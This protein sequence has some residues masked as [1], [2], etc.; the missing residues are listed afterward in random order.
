MVTIQELSKKCG[1]SISTVSK[2]LNGYSDISDKTREK[3]I[4]T[5]N[6]VGYYS[7]AN[8]K[9]YKLKKTYNIGV[10]FHTLT[11]LGLKN[12]YFAHIL[13]IFKDETAK[14]GYDIT[15]IENYIGGRKMSLLEH[16]KYRNFDGICIVCANYKD[17][18]VIRLANSD[19]P[20]VTIDYSFPTTYSIIS[21]NYN[22][23]KQLTN[24]IIQQ[25]HRDIAF[26]CGRKELLVTENRLRGFYDA[27]KENN[28]SIP[29][30]YVVEGSYRN[31]SLAEELALKILKDKNRH[32]SCIIAPDDLAAT[33]VL[34][35]IR[36]RRL[37][38]VRDVS[39]AGY[40]GMDANLF[41]GAKLTTVRQE[42]DIIGREAAQ[43]LVQMIENK[44]SVNLTTVYIKQSL[45]IGNS[46]KK[47]K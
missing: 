35:A 26:I 10:L 42:R 39:I 25:G 36:K 44:H 14:C 11:D 3:I 19:F 16:S 17:E 13:S 30:E 7:N 12:D 33:G 6:E 27:L 41:I 43:K 47:L 1:V 15:F 32:P 24:Y 21:D 37:Q 23:M 45:V 46:V 5:A 40:D 8:S 31:Y 2:A 9:S 22:G 4:K 38:P 18:E 20:V 28:I 29:E 34:S